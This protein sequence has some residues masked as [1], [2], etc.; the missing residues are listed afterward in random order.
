MTDDVCGSGWGAAA[1]GLHHAV[2]EEGNTHQVT[3]ATL[4]TMK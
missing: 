3:H 1:G 4:K 2:E